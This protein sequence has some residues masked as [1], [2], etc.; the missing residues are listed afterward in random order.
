MAERNTRIRKTQISSVGPD[1]F[2]A[3]NSPADNQ[4]P[5]YDN[6]T[7]K[8]TWANVEGAVGSGNIFLDE[9]TQADIESGNILVVTHDLSQQYPNVL[10]VDENDKQI[11]PDDIIFNSTS[12]LYIDLSSFVSITGTWHV[13]IASGGIDGATG[14]DGA[15][16]TSF[17]YKGLIDCSTNPNYPEGVVGDLY[18]V[19]VAGKIGGN[20]G[21]IVVVKNLILC[22]ESTVTGDEAT[23]G[24]KWAV[25]GGDMRRSKY[26]TDFDGI[27]DEAEAINDGTNYATAV[28][29]KSA[30]DLKHTQN[31][32][33][34]LD[35]G[36]AS[37]VSASQAKTG[38]THS[39]SNGAS[40]A[41]VASN[42]S[43]RGITGN[44]HG[45]VKGDV[46]LGNVDNK[47]EA[48]IITD[49][50]ADADVASAISL[51]HANT[52]DHSNASD[53][54]Q[55][56]DTGSTQNSFAIGDGND[57]DKTLTANTRVSNPPKLRYNTSTDK[58]QYTNDGTTWYDFGLGESTG[59][60]AK[61]VYDADNNGIVDKAS[62]V[63]DG[64][65]G[66]LHK[67]TAEQVRDAVDKKHT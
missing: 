63:D 27:V 36:G 64:T 49:V 45:T 1:D 33:T 28:N 50:K 7:G 19:S 41:D 56:T 38:Y 39:S 67:S 44:P 31:T 47:S 23:V 13:A 16:G 62:E 55:G 35:E 54:T 25:M 51:K 10:V 11:I 66:D 59:D 21:V 20:S 61:S 14:A 24:T 2:D 60:M 32:D 22:K 15:D 26:D 6:A 18:E 65:T 34:K 37:E 4:I 40:H 5:T 30:V 42:T 17:I 57:T 46:G 29:I 48:T 53:H 3:T 12:D 8:F 52:L 43:H 9:F 58:W